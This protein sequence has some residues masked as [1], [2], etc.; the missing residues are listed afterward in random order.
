[1]NADKLFIALTVQYKKQYSNTVSSLSKDEHFIHQTFY[2]Y[3]NPESKGNILM[4]DR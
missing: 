3:W 4:R 2:G 1:M